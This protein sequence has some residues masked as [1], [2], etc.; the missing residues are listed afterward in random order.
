MITLQKSRRSRQDDIVPM[1]NVA[2]LLL[3]F[4]LMSAVIAPPAPVKITA[5][6]TSE[7]SSTAEGERIFI[8]TDG[9]LFSEDGLE[10]QKLS[11]YAG[12][13]VSITAD[14]SLPANSFVQIIEKLRFAGVTE[15]A[16]V[17]HKKFE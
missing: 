11:D 17:A 2:F 6:S 12:R 9:R 3:V 1:I 8:A 16:L 15:I 10:I 14:A 5:P 4:F 7:S 13:A